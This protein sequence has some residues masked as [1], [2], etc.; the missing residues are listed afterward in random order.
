MTYVTNPEFLKD[1]LITFLSV[2]LVLE[3]TDYITRYLDKRIQWQRDFAK[4]LLLQFALAIVIPSVLGIAITYMQSRFI[5]HYDLLE[6]NYFVVEFPITVLIIFIVNLVFAIVYLVQNQA[7]NDPEI[8]ISEKVIGRRGNKSIPVT[9][10]N[11]ASIYLKNGSVFL[12][13]LNNEDFLLSGSIEQYEKILNMD[14]FRANRQTIINSR[15]CRSFQAVENGKIAVLLRPDDTT[16]L[17]SQKRAA[18]FRSW[19][20]GV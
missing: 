1:L 5:Y 7:D 2:F 6:T 12:T 16:V 19:I 10:E 8:A 14:F 17:V 20:K 9:P 11:I 13:T 15:A 18:R 4:R 3:Y